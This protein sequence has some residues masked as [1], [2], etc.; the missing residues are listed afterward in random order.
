MY[1]Y[2]SYTEYI[3]IHFIYFKQYAIP[4]YKNQVLKN[5]YIKR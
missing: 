1:I 4:S 2:N 3:N 5:I